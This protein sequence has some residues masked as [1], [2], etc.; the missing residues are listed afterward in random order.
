MRGGMFC[1]GALWCLVILGSAAAAEPALQ[2]IPYKPDPPPAIDGRLNEWENVPNSYLIQT[3][4]QVAHGG[5]AWKSP[6]DLSAKVWLAWR[7]DYLYLAADVTDDRHVQK[8]RG[9]DMWRGDHVELYLD[10][11]PDVDPK[12]THWGEGQIQMGLSPGNFQHTGDALTDIAPEAAV[13]RP[14]GGS[15]E[16]VLVAAQKTEKGYALEAAVPWAL[17][18]RLAKTPDLKPGAGMPLNFEVGISDTD[19]PESAQEKLMTILTT[20]WG[21]ERNRLVGAAL[22]PSDG[23]APAVVRGIDLSKGAEIAPKQ[24]GEIRF[25]APP[26]PKGKEGVLVLKARFQEPT[27]AGYNPGMWLELNGKVV[28]PKRLVNRQR[29]EQS[30]DG[31]VMHAGAGDLF[32]VVYAPDFDASDRSQYALQS[33]AKLALLELRVGDLLRPGDNRLVIENRIV[34]SHPHTLVVADV[35]LEIRTPIKPKPKR[36][37]PSGPLA[38]A[39]PERE[40]KVSY[41]LKKLPGA[42]L[43]LTLGGATFRI[44]SQFSTPQP[45]WVKGSNRYFDHQR[46]VELRDEA[47]VVR[48][49]FTNRSGENLPLMLRHRVM[50]PGLK[51]VW[52]AGLS[53]AG[54]VGS[55]SDPGNPSGYAVTAQ[56]GVGLIALDDVSQVH[57]TNF[58]GE[59][60]LGLADNECVLRPGATHTAEWAILP[61]AR[62]DYWAMLNALRRLRD[63]NFKLDGSFAFLRADPRQVIAHWTDQQF[64]DFIHFKDAR[65]L[66]DCYEWPSYKGRWPHGTALQTL[67]LSY[68]RG[69]MVRLRRLAPAAQHLLYFHCFLDVLDEAPQRYADARLL[70]ADGTQADYGAPYERIF[71]PTATNRF[72]RDIAKNVDMF[73]APLPKGFGCAGVYWDEFEY[74]RYQY[75]YDNFSGPTGLPWDGVS[76]DIDPRSMKISRLKSSVTL[77]SQPFRLALAKRILHDHVLIG[78][79]QPH[80]RTMTRLKFPRFVET[81]SISH[82]AAATVYTPVALGDHLTERSEADAYHVMLRALDYGCVYYWYNDLTVIPTHL[83]LTHYM[84]PITPVELH[85]GYII[86]QERILTNRS[87]LF[88]WGDSS[89]HEVHVFDDQGREV[90]G[91]KAATV[92]RDGMTFSELRLPEDYSAA[93]VRR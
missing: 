26:T 41:R 67:D 77:I 45:A 15:A 30:R 34:P 21:L 50:M 81:G 55:S 68:L 8:E 75:H 43:E 35:R 71:V 54:R 53:P 62:P 44:Q 88:G 11:T 40:H 79:G 51:K 12:R 86:G 61:T 29:E 74:S 19:G 73:L 69:Q 57:V 14:E 4:E 91:F 5:K 38:A 87:G 82:C 10:A 16:G 92:V 49:T 17:I 20:P 7:G 56:S 63:V 60:F 6:Q 48:D 39:M 80:T 33:G 46:E 78:N 66:N 93:I 52:L 59:G 24:N 36:P 2:G 64:L 25:Q 65:F 22:A 58:S 85:E 32:N 27:A 28:D 3:R 76:A 13:F 84:F 9:R 1:G 70:R 83:Q 72:G 47:I 31:R 37:A 42:A 18:A 90:P 89:R 23:K